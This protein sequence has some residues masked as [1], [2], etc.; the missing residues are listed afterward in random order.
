MEDRRSQLERYAVRI[1]NLLLGLPPG[2]ARL[3]DHL[4]KAVGDL[5]VELAARKEADAELEALQ[6]STAQVQDLVLGGADGPSSLAASMSAVVKMLEGR[7]DAAAAN[8]VRSRSRSALVVAV[9]H[10]LDLKT[11]LE[12]L[13]IRHS[14]DFTEDKADALWT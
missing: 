13:G 9:S 2:R 5:R 1:Y 8:G 3:A 4:D 6:T 7:I 14:T 10:F 11:E 12:V